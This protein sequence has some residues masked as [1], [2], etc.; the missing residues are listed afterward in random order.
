M[1][2]TEIARAMARRW[3]VVLVVAFIGVWLAIGMYRGAGLYTTTTVVEFTLPGHSGLLLW[4]GAEDA[5]VI[6]FASAVVQQANRGHHTFGY[7]QADAPHYGAGIR[8]GVWVGMPNLGGQ[9][10]SAF[11][12]ARV[13]IR[14]VGQSEDWVKETQQE[15]ID[16]VLG[17]SS[18]L[19]DRLGIESR[20]RIEATVLPLSTEVEHVSAS[21]STIAIAFTAIGSATFLVAAWAA[22]TLDRTL[23]RRKRVRLA[24]QS[25]TP[26]DEGSFST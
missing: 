26:A 14:V 3:Y 10:V 12:I 15:Q 11:G 7:G 6:A 8:E 20:E 1:A 13:E 25:T 19:Q 21:R 4:S 17:A 22:L 16:N 9:W 5:E 24:F 18:E 2:V 23:T